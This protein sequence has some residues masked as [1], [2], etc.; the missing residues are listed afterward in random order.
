MKLKNI[1]LLFTFMVCTACGGGERSGN[2]KETPIPLVEDSLVAYHNPVIRVATP[3]PTAIRANDGYYYL[4]ATEDIRNIPVFRSKDLI[5][6]EEVA[7]AF[8]DET[9]PDFAPGNKDNKDNIHA[10]I[11]APEIRYIKGKYVLFYSLA[12]WGNHWVST[13]G[14]ALSDSPTGPFEV[15]G[16]VFDSREVNVGN[17][18]DQF[19]YE[20]NGTY[21]ML[22][23]SFF[24]IY[25]MELDIA[26]DFTITPKLETKRQIAGTAYEG[27][28]LWKRDGYY[29]L[30]AS[31]GSCCEGGNSTYTTVVGRSKDL[32]GPY[33]NKQGEKMLENKHE[34]ILH[35]NDRFVG[36]GHNSVLMEDDKRDTW[37]LYHAYEL[38]HLDTQRQVLLDHVCW[39]DEGWPY[40]ENQEPSYGAFRPVINKSDN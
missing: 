38:E 33:V 29:Y 26:E 21:Y 7:T 22:W 23:G 8:T 1:F 31:I 28:N 15:K 9:R 11:W 32:L 27:I 16:Y 17:S 25:I 14:Y 12:Q 3:D 39:D 36:T 20:E 19:F 37:M 35:G 34:I 2:T 18:I 6:W 5:E 30:F 40:I 4:Y 24:G 13:V 10:A